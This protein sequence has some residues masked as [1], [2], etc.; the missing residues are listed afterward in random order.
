M[1]G[2]INEF[3]KQE[4]LT[5]IRE[6]EKSTDNTHQLLENLLNWSRVQIGKIL[7]DPTD[8][9]LYA[10]LEKIRLLCIQKAEMKDIEIKNEIP[11]EMMIRA[12]R[13][14]MQIILKNL[15]ENAI[16]FTYPGGNIRIT[17]KIKNKTVH[18]S[19]IDNG[20]G[21]KKENLTRL[22]NVDSIY[23][24]QG[25]ANEKG[26]GLGL[27]LCQEFIEKNKGTISAISEFGK[28][29]TFTIALPL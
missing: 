8:F 7:Y 1:R 23:V 14:M 22:F 15:L 11:S 18:I 25:T 28:G 4:I 5:L 3:S 27:I 24:I 13:F 9:D 2:K 26:T 17:E 12:D 29:S 20:I 16:K 6:L 19:V 21:I 10:L